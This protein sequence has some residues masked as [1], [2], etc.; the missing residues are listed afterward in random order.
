VLLGWHLSGTPLPLVAA[1]LLPAAAWAALIARVDRPAAASPALLALC[2]L[3]GAAAAAVSSAAANDAVQG[4]LTALGHAGPARVLTPRLLA[5]A[6]EEAAKAAPLLLLL[7]ARGRLRSVRAGIVCGGLIGAGFSMT[8]NASYFLLAAV[9]GGAAGLAQSIYLRAMLGGLNHA[10][11]TAL[12]G[13][14]V[15][16]GRARGGRW[17]G[18]GPALG[19]LAAVTAHGLWNSIAAI[20]LD[21]AVCNPAMADGACRAPAPA[22]TLLVVAPLLIALGLAPS[23]ALLVAAARRLDPS[24]RGAR[25]RQQQRFT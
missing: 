23:I 7:A 20:A 24:R 2:F 9:Q 11:F 21:R 5:P 4:W 17:R 13:A 25:H 15:G 3:W 10:A 22:L 19:M 16:Y 14:G 18:L 12:V 6:I 8:E 1:A